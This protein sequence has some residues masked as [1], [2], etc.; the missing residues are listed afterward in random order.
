MFSLRRTRDCYTLTRYLNI[1][2]L[3]IRPMER[4]PIP[5][6]ME[7][8]LTDSEN[9]LCTLLDGCTKWMKEEKG[10]ETSCR[11]AGGWVRDKASIQIILAVLLLT[12]TWSRCA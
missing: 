10:V 3:S 9:E 8:H 5:K 6:K 12:C 11:I 1:R 7:I 4:I 2:N